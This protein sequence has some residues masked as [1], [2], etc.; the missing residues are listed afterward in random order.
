MESG[1]MTVG[2]RFARSYSEGWSEVCGMY[3]LD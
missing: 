3:V 2:A 1:N